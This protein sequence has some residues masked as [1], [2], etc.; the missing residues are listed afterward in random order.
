MKKTTVDSIPCIWFSLLKLF[1]PSSVKLDSRVLFPKLL[2]WKSIPVLIYILAHSSVF[3]LQTFV[4]PISAFKPNHG[5]SRTIKPYAHILILNRTTV[6]DMPVLHRR[7][8]YSLILVLV[9]T[10]LCWNHSSAPPISLTTLEFRLYQFQK[11]P[12]VANTK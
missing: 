4:K 9:L 2:P 7:L 12:N 10:A 3:W 5:S 11:L 8:K 6:S 1:L